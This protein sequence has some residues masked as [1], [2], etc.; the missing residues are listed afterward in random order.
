MGRDSAGHLVA[1]TILPARREDR[2]S[3]RHCYQT[4][5]PAG[6]VYRTPRVPIATP[7]EPTP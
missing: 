6:L 1:A 5:T 3:E 2:G 7:K 4:Y